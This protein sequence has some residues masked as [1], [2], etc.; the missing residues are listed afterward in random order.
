MVA[1]LEKAGLVVIGRVL[2]LPVIFLGWTVFRDDLS[3]LEEGPQPPEAPRLTC[4][5]HQVSPHATRQRDHNAISKQTER[6][7]ACRMVQ[8]MVWH[9]GRQYWSM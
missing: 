4:P 1:L 3:V 6:F 2:V 9:A 8:R 5:S 7:S